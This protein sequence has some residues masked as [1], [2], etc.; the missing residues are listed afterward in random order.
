[1]D[2]KTIKALTLG[3][4][5]VAV[6]LSYWLLRIINQPIEFE[7]IK[8]DRYAAIIERLEQIREVQQAHLKENGKY[9]ADFDVLI[10]FV[11]TGAITLI[12]RKDSSFMY[13][14]KIYQQEMNKDTVIERVLGTQGVKEN[15]FDPEFDAAQLRFIP[16]PGDLAGTE[17]F[18]IGAS[19]IERNGLRIPVFE[20][21][22]PN[23]VIFHDLLSSDFSIFVDKDYSLKIGSLTE[24]KVTGNWK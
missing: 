14:D 19:S 1:M 2:K 15:L 13:Y 17:E 8:S 9:A 11:D 23:T 24:P 12:E 21:G 10:A 4:T 6:G 7:K 5:L 3:L 22:A 20:V 16:L 18:N